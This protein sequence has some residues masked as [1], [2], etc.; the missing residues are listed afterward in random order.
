MCQA[1]TAV[2][3]SE[4]WKKAGNSKAIRVRILTGGSRDRTETGAR[5][6]SSQSDPS[7]RNRQCHENVMAAK[8]PG[9][10]QLEEAAEG[11][12]IMALLN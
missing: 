9:G 1:L 6:S 11:E 12:E 4:L 10:N 2:S 8:H 3:V 7:K 5:G